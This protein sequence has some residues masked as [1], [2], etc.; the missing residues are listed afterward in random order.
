MPV[1]L[2]NAYSRAR[3]HLFPKIVKGH[4]VTLNAPPILQNFNTFNASTLCVQFANQRY[5]L[6]PK[7]VEMGHVTDPVYLG[8]VERHKAD[9]SRGQQVY[10]F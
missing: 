10:E 5:G 9:S 1:W 6:G 3:V 7:N 8:I 2:E 4:D